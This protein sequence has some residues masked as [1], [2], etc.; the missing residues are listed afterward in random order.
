[1][2]D[3]LSHRVGLVHNTYDRDLEGNQD[4][5]TLTQKLA[6]APSRASRAS[7]TATRTSPSA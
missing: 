3:V 5:R 6:Y 7:A 1:V 2:A 4:Y